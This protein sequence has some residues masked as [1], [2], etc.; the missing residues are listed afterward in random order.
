V[1]RQ[2]FSERHTNAICRERTKDGRAG[3]GEHSRPQT[4]TPSRQIVN[5][6]EGSS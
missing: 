1:G 2:G 4:A 6:L 3:A 5:R